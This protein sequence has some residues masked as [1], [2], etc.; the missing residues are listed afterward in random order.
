MAFA[1]IS[2]FAQRSFLKGKAGGAEKLA[3]AAAQQI[4]G[5]RLRGGAAGALAT[6]HLGRGGAEQSTAALGKYAGSITAFVENFS[7]ELELLE[8][9]LDIAEDVQ[10]LRL[11][12]GI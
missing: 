1:N 9:V 8:L 4:S 5:C 10:M 6:Q 11:M 2:F 12:V 7:P 3:G